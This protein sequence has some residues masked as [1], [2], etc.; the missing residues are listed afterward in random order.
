MGLMSQPIR[1]T[2][3]KRFITGK[4]LY[5]DD[6]KMAG[7]AVGYALRSPYAHAKILSIDIAA[8]KAMPG[9]IG[10]IVGADLEAAGIG[11]LGAA[12]PAAF[13]KSRD[14]TPRVDGDRA[15]LTVDYVRYVGEPVAFTLAP[16]LAV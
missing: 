14:G 13:L 2:E 6:V 8:A 11:H 5:V 4:G 7:A 1:R 12:F 3:D 16:S 15:L 10:I 9:V